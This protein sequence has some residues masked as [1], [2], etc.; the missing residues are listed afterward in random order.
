MGQAKGVLPQLWDK[1][2]GPRRTK[3]ELIVPKIVSPPKPAEPLP[4]KMTAAE[5][6]ERVGNNEL[7]VRREVEKA[8]GLLLVGVVENF[9]NGYFGSGPLVQLRIG[10]YKKVMAYLDSSQEEAA[11]KI[12]SGE[13][14]TLLCGRPTNIVKG[15]SAAVY[16]CVFK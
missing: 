10:Q 12:N 4:L 5:L 11:I 7:R 2:L 16:G 3:A 9:G 8:K 6:L 1:Y 13:K 15:Y 14:V